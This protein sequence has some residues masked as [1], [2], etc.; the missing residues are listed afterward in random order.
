MRVVVARNGRQRTLS[1]T[2]V[3]GRVV[4]EPGVAAPPG[5]RP[6]GIIGV[7]FDSPVQRTGAL[8]AVATTGSD[9]GHVT[10]AAITGVGHLFT[11]SSVVHRFDQV[12][13]AKAA[14]QAA[15][16]GTRA[17][18]I[19]GVVRTGNQ[20][21]QAGVGDFLLVLITINVFFGI[22]NLFPMLPL[23]GGHVAL[24]VYEKIRT[25]R[26]ATMYHADAAK[27]MPLAW[28][29]MAFLAVIV[30]TAL[31]TDI[32]HPAANPFG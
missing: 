31:L 28:L 32:L 13:S 5:N 27:L 2:P 26:R 24:A 3:N 14:N 17:Q 22:F 21:V 16:D 19:V 8:H 25:G 23:D 1:V 9:L 6:F 30:G 10:W 20:A 15:A 11:P 18:S 29:M 12:T 4:H 7:T